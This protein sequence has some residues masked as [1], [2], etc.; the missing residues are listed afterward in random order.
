MRSNLHFT[1][2]ARHAVSRCPEI[3]G[4]LG[5]TYIGSEHLLLALSEEQDSVAAHF[6]EKKGCHSEKLR[7]T[8]SDFAGIGSPTT[9]F[10]GDMTPRL[11]RIIDKAGADA[12]QNAAVVGTEHLLSA[13]LSEK[14]AVA[15]R[16]LHTVGVESEELLRDLTALQG[17]EKG[18]EVSYASPLRDTVYLKKYGRDLTE[19]AKQGKLDPLVGREE[20]SERV[21]RI[22]SRRTKNNPCL[23]G[24]PGV[25]KT[26][27]VEGLALRIAQRRVPKELWGHGIILLDLCAMI[28]GAKYRGE[29]E[30][31][32]KGVLEEVGR[33]AKVIL[34]VD[35]MHM[36]VGAGAAEG[37]VDAANIL[38]PALARGTLRLIGATTLKEYRLHIEKDAALSRRFG[39]VFVGEPTE[40][41]TMAV[42]RGLKEKY[43]LH[44]GLT[45]SEEAMEQAVRLSGR[46]LPERF[47]PDKAIDLLDEAAA[48]KRLKVREAEE[49]VTALQNRLSSLCEE[50][51][52][53]IAEEDFAKAAALREEE[54]AL[55][56]KL[57]D[58][59]N[60][61]NAFRPVVLSE[62]V[63]EVLAAQTGIAV[64]K[65]T[66][67]E[68]ER[69]S[70]LEDEINKRI[71]G[72]E[73]AKRAL[74]HAVRRARL[75]LRSPG[76]PIGCFLFIGP[77]GVGKTALCY[78]LA[79]CLYDDEGAVIRL[80]M[81]EYMEKH[82]VSRLVGSPP[83]YVG[84]EEGGQL[85]ER[86]RRRPYS[87]VVFDEIEKAHPD[88]C[89]L[90]L[91]VMENGML[92]DSTGRRVDFSGTILVLTSN[93][94]SENGAIRAPLGFHTSKA[95][96]SERESS[97]V[98][99]FF[100][101]E[102]LNR[103]DDIIR[104][105]PL[106]HAERTQ[107]A[108][109]MLEE[110]RKRAALAGLSLRFDEE[111]ATFIAEKGAEEGT[112]AR[113][114]RRAI[115]AHVEDSLSAALLTGTISGKKEITIR[116][117]GS[118]LVPEEA[119]DA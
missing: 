48:A 8:V 5:H 43:E 82:A 87:V 9:V 112:D 14:D 64:G 27:I 111:V 89:G 59:T 56:Q 20:E 36:L 88:V 1:P 11:R 76:R 39:A 65:L 90:L 66:A 118:C 94:G 53:A 79:A 33:T 30:D 13:L 117:K 31:R 116:R 10:A 115:A 7:Q 63:A 109:M 99:D 92:T 102:F 51:L 98:K 62:D 58:T 40:E 81:T 67:D 26:A 50:K 34:F 57:T 22:L 72:Q 75:G 119:A 44:H 19:M 17:R 83:G 101:P 29:F 103:L 23:I 15:C 68:E 3:A 108:E 45:V 61:E 74:C 28:A 55:R 18:E 37:A 42:L 47:F 105:H 2:K 80:D 70:H 12:A 96:M 73:E 77:S 78:A 6:L 16:L 86:V 113:P 24:E 93:I 54:Q 104:F 85:T 110:L 35:E 60:Q 91:Q 38:K 69:L 114:L 71:V 97:A 106:S 25:G 100:R 46:Y 4:Q 84:Y 32:L 107:V 41:E 21:I 49:P 95:A 52:A